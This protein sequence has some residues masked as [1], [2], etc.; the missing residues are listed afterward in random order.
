MVKAELVTLEGQVTADSIDFL[1]H[2]YV[3]PSL[4]EKANKT[5]YPCMDIGC[6]KYHLFKNLRNTI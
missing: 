2:K 3:P 5:F 6:K 4:I 1:L